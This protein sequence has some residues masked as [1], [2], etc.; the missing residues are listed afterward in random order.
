MP[1]LVTELGVNRY[2]LMAFRA[3]KFL[4][5]FLITGLRQPAGKILGKHGRHHQAHPGAHSHAG[6]PFGFRCLFHGHGGFH[7]HEFVHVIKDTHPAAVVNGLLDLR[8]RGDGT[9]VD[10]GQ[11][12]TKMPEIFM[13]PF[14]KTFGEFIVF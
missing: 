8:G 13:Q 1:A 10:M 12:D 2:W 4:L 14:G 11:V 6:P 5:L 9:D 3:G 7:L